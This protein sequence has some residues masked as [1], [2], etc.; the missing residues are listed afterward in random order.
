MNIFYILYYKHPNIRTHHFKFKQ[1]LI[2]QDHQNMDVPEPYDMKYV[3][4]ALMQPFVQVG[5]LHTSPY[6]SHV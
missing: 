1:I 3:D 4:L 2:Y 6:S 5:R